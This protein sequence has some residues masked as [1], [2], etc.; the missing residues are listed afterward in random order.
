MSFPI[1]IIGAGGWGTAL[2]ITMPRAA[3][4]VRLW[5]YEPYLVE[6]IIATRENPMYLPSARVPGT[7][8]VSN[9]MKDVLSGAQIVIIAVPSHVYRAVVSEWKRLLTPGMYFA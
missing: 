7:E 4:E 2:A 6:T 1:A 8:R 5:A 9:S 3:R